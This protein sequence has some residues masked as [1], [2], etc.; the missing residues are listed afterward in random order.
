M[1]DDP[2]AAY[3]R[4]RSQRN[5]MGLEQGSNA[6][7]PDQAQEPLT[8]HQALKLAIDALNQV[9]NYR[10]MSG[11]HRATY[12]LIPLLARAYERGKAT[13]K[14]TELAPRMLDALELC[15]DAL[16]DLA[17]DDDGT[18]SIQALF[19]I[20]D[21]KNQLKRKPEPAPEQKTREVDIEPER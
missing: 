12:D 21:I 3:R 20:R 4:E 6:D 11:E 15:E 14:L 1:S 13:E 2:L 10:L 8:E 5:G 18:P 17:R 7:K 19:D 16:S 9:P